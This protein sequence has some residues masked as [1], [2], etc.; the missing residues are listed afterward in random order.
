M[1]NI[2]QLSFESQESIFTQSS[3]LAELNPLSQAGDDGFMFESPSTGSPIT[4]STK[5]WVNEHYIKTLIEGKIMRVCRAVNCNKQYSATSSTKVFKLHWCREHAALPGLKKTRFLFHDQLQI[6]RLVKAVII[7][8]WD[9]SDVER[10]CFRALWQSLNPNKRLICRRTLSDI[11]LRSRIKLADMITSAL[12]NAEGVSLTFD[13]WSVRKGAR[14]FGCITAHYINSYGILVNVILNFKRMKYP[15]DAQTICDFI[16]KTITANKLQGKVVAITTDNASNN[17]SAMKKLTQAINLSPLESVNLKFVHYKCVA[18]VFD[19]GVRQAMKSLK[20]TV[21]AVREV[22]LAIRSS[23][24][25]K[26]AFADIQKRLIQD[27]KQKT[28]GPLELAED[29]DH[30]WNSALILIERAFLLREAIDYMLEHT[31]GMEGM[32][33]IDWPTLEVVIE[34]LKPFHEASKKLCSASDVTISFVSFVVPRLLDHCT[35]F[36]ANEI[37]SIS[38]AAKSLKAKLTNYASELYHPIVNLA[39]VLDPR[40]KT[41]HLS[42]EVARNVRNQLREL[43]DKIPAPIEE[44]TNQSSSVLCIESDDEPMDELETYL[45][46]RR[47]KSKSEALVWWRNNCE[48]YPKLTSLARK[49]LPVQATSVASERVF[50]TA[51][52]VDSKQRNRLSDESIEN[53]VLFN[54]WMQFLNIE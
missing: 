1:T 20:E 52:E 35:K 36:E 37:V 38:D 39:Y 11:I 54:S 29:V 22:V 32:D 16:S 23:S 44:H 47:E 21:R 18:H 31:Q 46:S 3:E 14:G 42:D 7:L 34:F 48:L 28:N 51:G 5:G 49:I 9:Y 53:I 12:V 27:G 4:P 45:S 17:I 15:H 41:K 10:P 26:E 40:Y 13:I 33:D 2:S 19:L 6:N 30:R 43:M 8:H 50:S 25:R 24:K